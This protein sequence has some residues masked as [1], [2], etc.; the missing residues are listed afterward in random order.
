MSDQVGKLEKQLEGARRRTEQL[1]AELNDAEQ[2]L[3]FTKSVTGRA[4]S[5]DGEAFG[6]EVVK[7]T[8]RL[9]EAKQRA[10]E[11]KQKAAEEALLALFSDLETTLKGLSAKLSRL[12]AENEELRERLDELTGE[13]QADEAAAA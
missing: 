13:P 4:G 7:M 5:F 11:A 8:S 12:E 6:M 9:V 1:E 2:R 10:M 3:Q